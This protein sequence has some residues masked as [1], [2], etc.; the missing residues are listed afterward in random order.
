MCKV[1]V[2]VPIYNVE[3][4]L[5]RCLDSIMAQTFTDFECILVDDGSPDNCPKI[6]DEYIKK[7]KRFKVIHKE[8]GGLSSA[9][10]AGIDVATGD[11]ISF[12][13]SDDWIACDF[14]EAL[15][16]AITKYNAD[17]AS[18]GVKRVLPGENPPYKIAAEY[19]TQLFTSRQALDDFYGSRQFATSSSCVKLYKKSCFSQI[20]FPEGMLSED[21]WV[22]RRILY[23]A[24]TLVYVEG[25][26]YFY[27]LRSNSITGLTRPKSIYDIIA[28]EEDAALFW[29]N[30][31]EK[32]WETAAVNQIIFFCLLAYAQY[33]PQEKEL[34]RFCDGFLIK[35]R[36]LNYKIKKKYKLA[37]AIFII[38][39]P[40]YVIPAKMFLFLYRNRFLLTRYLMIR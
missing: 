25:K 26:R 28:I 32:K 13:D 21:V 1:S 36:K 12:I 24:N 39:K 5:A 27:L 29:R 31:N 30:L 23:S 6:C 16:F 37:L 17:I 7:D 34:L 11:Y 33:Y 38:S 35:Y 2:I 15:L 3:K 22:N 8:N 40:F 10:N 14:I 4:Y 18:T 20:R 19:K 9:R